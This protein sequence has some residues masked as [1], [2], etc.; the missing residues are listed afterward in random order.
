MAEARGR[1]ERAQPQLAGQRGQRVDG[2]PGVELPALRMLALEIQ[3]VVGAKPGRDA[4]SLARRGKVT[5][6][7]PGHAFLT[8]DHQADVHAGSSLVEGAAMVFI[9]RRAPSI[10]DP[11]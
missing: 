8:L 3:V 6:L 2:G 1:S 4:V 10:G 11:N 9:P 5:P 7:R